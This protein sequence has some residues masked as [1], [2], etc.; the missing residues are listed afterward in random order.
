MLYRIY[1]GVIMSKLYLVRCPKCDREN[2][3][4][5]VSSG[6]CTWCGYV[7]KEEDDDGIS[8]FSEGDS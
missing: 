7:A 1:G 4:M 3:S 2:Y 8:V 6:Y 5:A